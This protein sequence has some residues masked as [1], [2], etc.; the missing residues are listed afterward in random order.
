MEK[1]PLP[2]QKYDNLSKI[3]HSAISQE[4][5]HP[6]AALLHGNHHLFQDLLTHTYN[7]SHFP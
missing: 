7:V 5:P 3:I 4:A 6:H 1:N 2:K